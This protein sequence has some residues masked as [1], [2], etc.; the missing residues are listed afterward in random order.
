M[1]S[2]DFRS[3]NGRRRRAPQPLSILAAVGQPGRV[4]LPENLPFELGEDGEQA[5]H[6][7]SGG[8]GQVQY[9]S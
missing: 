1:Q 8:R 3:V 4:R 6:G 7:A 2:P 5:C 9:L